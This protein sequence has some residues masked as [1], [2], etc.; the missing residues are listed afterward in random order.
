MYYVL[1]NMLV[2]SSETFGSY[3]VSLIGFEYEVIAV[4]TQCVSVWK[5][6]SNVVPLFEMPPL[7]VHLIFL[8]CMDICSVVLMYVSDRNRLYRKQT[9]VKAFKETQRS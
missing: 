7:Q 4:I 6:D 2:R 8:R 9:P 3:N 5:A 1:L